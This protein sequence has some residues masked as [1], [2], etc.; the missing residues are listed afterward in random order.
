MHGTG[1]VQQRDCHCCRLLGSS[2]SSR[3]F[4]RSPRGSLGSSSQSSSQAPST[5]GM[6]YWLASLCGEVPTNGDAAAQRRAAGLHAAAAE[7][8]AKL[9]EE[10]GKASAP[11]C[12]LCAALEPETCA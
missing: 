4:G 7:L 9:K 11:Q 1:P 12:G 3:S 6:K 2:K 5:S 8:R 10:G